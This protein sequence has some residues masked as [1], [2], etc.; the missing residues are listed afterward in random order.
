MTALGTSRRIAIRA[1][2]RSRRS[3][4]KKRSL[5]PRLSARADMLR[6]MDDQR[7]LNYTPLANARRLERWT[8]ENTSGRSGATT[9]SGRVSSCS[10]ANPT[11]EKRV[12]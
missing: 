8:L 2:S 4:P 9:S 1:F 5:G 11:A 3:L 10:A 6:R 7:D 12:C